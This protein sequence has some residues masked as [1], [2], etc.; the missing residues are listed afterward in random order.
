MKILYWLWLRAL[1]LLDRHD[2]YLSGDFPGSDYRR[3]LCR[4]CPRW[5]LF[6]AH[7]DWIKTPSAGD[8]LIAEEAERNGNEGSG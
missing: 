3:V 1:C 2:R 5:W 4:R 8:R 7:G 6:S